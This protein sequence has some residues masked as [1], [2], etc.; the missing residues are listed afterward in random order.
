MSSSIDY[1]TCP[2]CGCE[3]A[4]RD[5]DNRSGEVVFGCPKCDWQGEPVENKVLKQYCK[6]VSGYVAQ[7]FVKKGK[8]YVC[9]SQNF[10][11][12]D[13]VSWEDE[14]G[15]SVSIDDSKE[16]YFPYEMKQPK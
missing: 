2:K 7:S 11:A 1:F 15:D 13:D 12:S 9:V 10:I 3:S 16:V 4:F 5:Q 14:S 8:K 6:F